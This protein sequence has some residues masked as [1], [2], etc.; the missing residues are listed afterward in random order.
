MGKLEE[1]GR[2]FLNLENAEMAFYLSEGDK[3]IAM[4][5]DFLHVF[6]RSLEHTDDADIQLIVAR[7]H[8][9]EAKKKKAKKKMNGVSK[10]I[11]EQE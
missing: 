1:L 8:A 3:L 11:K 6:K 10:R 7:L 5:Q 4:D 2:I 9:L